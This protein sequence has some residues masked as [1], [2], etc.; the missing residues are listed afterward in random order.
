MYMTQVKVTCA[1]SL[2]VPDAG[3]PV[4]DDRS[5]QGVN[6]HPC[7]LT[8]FDPRDPASVFLRGADSRTSLWGRKDLT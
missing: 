8:Q 2:V 6:G 7:H 3:S 5:S 4:E 1:Y